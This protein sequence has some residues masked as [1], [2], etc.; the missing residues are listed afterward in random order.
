M[1]LARWLSAPQPLG[2]LFIALAAVGA[3]A[4]ALGRPRGRTRRASQAARLG[5]LLLALLIPAVAMYPSLHVFATEA[6]ERLVATEFGPQAASQREDF[7]SRASAGGARSD[8]CDAD[9]CVEFVTSSAE[10]AAPT[11][12]RAFLVWSQTELAQVPV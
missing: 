7:C 12:D 2:P 4:A 11:T 8:R 5:A 6:K 9:R 10:D 3:C 1:G